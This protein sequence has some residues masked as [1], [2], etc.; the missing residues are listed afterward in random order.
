MQDKAFDKVANEL[1]PRVFLPEVF[2]AIVDDTL[3]LFYRG[4][5]EH[6]NPYNYNI[7]FICD[8]GLNTA[9]YFEVTPTVDQIGDHRL[10][11]NVRDHLD[12]ILTTAESII[13]VHAVG[14]SPSQP[15]NI[16]CVGDSL[17]SRG[18]WCSETLRRLT[19]TGG[20]PEGLGLS[21]IR[22]IGTKKNGECGYEGYGGWTWESY[23]KPPTGTNL[24]MWTYCIH[25]KTSAD[26]HSLWKD[27]SGNIW[28]METIEES[29]IKFTRYQDH[30]APMP[31]GGGILHH[32]QN[33][34][35]TAAIKYDE[36]VYAESN[37]FWDSGKAQVDFQTYCKRNGFDR[38]DYMVTLLSW[39][40]MSVSYHRDNEMNISNHVNN[41][42]ALIRILHVQYPLAKVKMM[43]IQMPSVNGG[44]G[45]NYGANREY[46]NWYGLVRSVM[47][48]NYAY[49]EMANDDE[50]KDF[51]EFINIS[52]QFDS[53]Y[54]LP[55]H[56]KAVNTRSTVTEYIGTNGVHPSTDGY[57][58]IGD[59]AYR[60]LVHELTE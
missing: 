48:L 56:S 60:A 13:R 9:R 36:T 17:T 32:Y 35:H 15:Q 50:F 18:S 14:K 5:V 51:V 10:T 16:L 25:D 6:P 41:A 1:P 58:Q 22:F 11:V 45:N 3:Q 31:V 30:T 49:Q 8:I 27:E 24:G 29:R 28:S 57:Y 2:H 26:Q 54:N 19:E 47:N 46:S 4:L 7:E 34:V 23:L 12:N 52:G 38:V 53:E 39:N 43:G 37:P 42:K 40:G 21:N 55:Y 59:A 44:T 20:K 33:A